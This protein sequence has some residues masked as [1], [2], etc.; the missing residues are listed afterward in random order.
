MPQKSARSIKK[1]RV[2]LTELFELTTA[3]NTPLRIVSIYYTVSMYDLCKNMTAIIIAFST[4]FR[5]Y[6]S[7]FFCQQQKLI[8]SLTDS[9]QR[10]TAAQRTHSPPLPG[11]FCP[12]SFPCQQG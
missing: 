9:P 5:N 3:H 7:E 10:A 6:F 4:A 12:Q 1:K 11:R 8:G 2:P